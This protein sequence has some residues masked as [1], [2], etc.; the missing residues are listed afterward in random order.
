VIKYDSGN[1]PTVL[2]ELRT[3]CWSV[4]PLRPTP[5]LLSL[6]ALPV[7]TLDP[8]RPV[9]ESR[10]SIP[11]SFGS[12]IHPL[13]HSD[14]GA[15]GLLPLASVGIIIHPFPFHIHPLQ[16]LH[17]HP[18]SSI[19]LHPLSSIHLHSRPSIH[20]CYPRRHH[21]CPLLF[22]FY[23]FQHSLIPI[24]FT[25]PWIIPDILHVTDRIFS[26]SRLLQRTLDHLPFPPD[27]SNYVLT[28]LSPAGEFVSLLRS[29]PLLR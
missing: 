2:Y 5:Y 28:T 26:L 20:S 17:L 25:L 8:S 19:H 10:P 14:T 4:H 22:H 16:P 18:L 9:S 3:A 6:P 27:P 13:M 15:N 24:H 23:L 29:V 12:S 21:P 11:L 7:N 1:Q